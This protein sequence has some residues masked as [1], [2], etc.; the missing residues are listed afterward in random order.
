MAEGRDI[1]D[2]FWSKV[3]RSGG[4][5][6][7]WPWLPA[8]DPGSYGTFDQTRAHR[9]AYE[10][11]VG[12]IPEGLCLDHLCRHP[13]CV[14]P[15]HLE[16]VTHRENVL[17]GNAP[18][19]VNAAKTHCPQGHEYD[20]ENTYVG[21]G[22]SHRYCRAC[23]REEQRRRAATGYYRQRRREGKSA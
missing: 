1:P 15:A 7:C 12:S 18:M 5:D 10:L 2:R 14:N 20:E 3:D 17:R 21:E 4:P 9:V 6:N 11:L 22:G 19:A 13:V 16:P 23:R 8:K